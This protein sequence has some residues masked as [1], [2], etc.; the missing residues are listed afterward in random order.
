MRVTHKVQRGDIIRAVL[1]F[2]LEKM[3]SELQKLRGLLRVAKGVVN[4]PAL[5]SVDTSC[6]RGR[7][8]LT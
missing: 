4:S 1:E 8:S 5:I 6:Y 2:S 3:N 7:E